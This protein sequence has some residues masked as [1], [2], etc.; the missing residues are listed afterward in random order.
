M[1]WFHRPPAPPPPPPPP[2]QDLLLQYGFALF[3]ALLWIYGCQR[4]PREREQNSRDRERSIEPPLFNAAMQGSGEAVTLLVDAGCNVDAPSVGGVTALAMAVSCH[5]NDIVDILLAAK[6]DCESMSASSNSS[7]LRGVTALLLA[8]R[9]AN[10][11]AARSLIAAGANVHARVAADGPEEVRG[12]R[13]R[14]IA[15]RG[16]IRAGSN[17][18][19]R[20]GLAEL[21]KD[22]RMCEKKKRPDRG[23]RI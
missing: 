16:L 8:V 5:N 9:S 7:E 6:A 1:G 2:P 14:E 20:E 13:A 22:L 23:H 15:Q 12:M 17:A 11:V 4:R 21:A 3:A 18:C 10:I 19:S